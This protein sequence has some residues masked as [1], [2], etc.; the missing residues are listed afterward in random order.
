MSATFAI[1]RI[2]SA[3][4]NIKIFTRRSDK[5]IWRSALQIKKEAIV[6]IVIIDKLS[7]DKL[8]GYF[9]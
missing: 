7:D 4:C 5:P 2:G 3:F 8:L 9:K 1:K 6:V